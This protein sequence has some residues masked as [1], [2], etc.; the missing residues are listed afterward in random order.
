[1]D[2][3]DGKEGRRLTFTHAGS[4]FSDFGDCKFVSGLFGTRPNQ[5]NLLGLAR[6]ACI[7][8]QNVGL[9]LRILTL[10]IF[11]RG[12]YLPS[13]A[14]SP[15]SCAF[16]CPGRLDSYLTTASVYTVYRIP[17]KSRA[18]YPACLQ[19]RWPPPLIRDR[20]HE[21]VKWRMIRPFIICAC[22]CRELCFT[23]LNVI[24]VCQL[25]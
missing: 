4:E 18:G 21:S 5:S 14:R 25:N 9:A 10:A 15:T 1:V 16:L 23:S 7:I 12:F 20:M 19:V 6:S 11:I 2:A 17:V 13:C 24:V 22:C 3:T 8:L